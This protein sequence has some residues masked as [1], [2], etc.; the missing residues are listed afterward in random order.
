MH[1]QRTRIF[2]NS[3]NTGRADIANHNVRA[4]GEGTKIMLYRFKSVSNLRNYTIASCDTARRYRSCKWRGNKTLCF[5][6][7]KSV[8][9][10]RNYTI[11]SCDT[12]RRYRSCVLR[13]AQIVGMQA[14][15]LARN[16]VT[17]FNIL[18]GNMDLTCRQCHKLVGRHATTPTKI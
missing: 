18:Q 9:N 7:F 17:A 10:L 2:A 4:S 6:V 15:R 5:I 13:E 1:P 16:N 3:F 12:A 11:A 14:W 8:S